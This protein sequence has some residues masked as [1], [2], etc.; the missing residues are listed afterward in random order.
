MMRQQ[1]VVVS[2]SAIGAVFTVRQIEK[3]ARRRFFCDKRTSS[4]YMSLSMR[5]CYELTSMQWL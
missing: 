1:V 2:I 3:V 4:M 5:V